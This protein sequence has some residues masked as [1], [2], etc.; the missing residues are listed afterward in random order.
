MF[1]TQSE[2]NTSITQGFGGRPDHYPVIEAYPE[3]LF[4]IQRNQN[5]NTVIYELNLLSGDMLNL[6]DPIKISWMYFE[7]GNHQKVQEINF[8]QKKLAYGYHHQVISNDLISFKFVSYDDMT[9][10]LAKNNVG[11][12]KVITK[13]KGAYVEIDHIY[14]YAE[15]F[16]VFPQV[17]FVEFFGS[18]NGSPF[19]HKLTLE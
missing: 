7:D 15:D 12:Y 4:Y 11:Q 2:Q 6:N 5:I 1:F 16:G 10:Y 3:L 14:V 19:Y 13:I 9:F 8:I 17:K 18:N